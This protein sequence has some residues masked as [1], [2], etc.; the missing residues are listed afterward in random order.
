M[1]RI[2]GLFSK[3]SEPENLRQ[4]FWRAARGKADRREVQV[5]RAR[6]EDELAALGKELATNQWTPQGYRTFTVFEPKERRIHAAPFRDRVVHHAIV[7][8]CD[9]VFER[10]AIADSF[11][12]RCGK[13]QV[14]AAQRTQQFCRRH[15]FALK[16]DVRKYF[17][18]VDHAVLQAQLARVFREPTLLKIWDTVLA[19]YS[20]AS[21]RGLPI[22][23]LTSQHL[24]NFHL[25]ALDRFVKERLRR[26][27]YVR[28]M[29]DFLIWGESRVELTAV[30]REVAAFLHDELKLD[31][32]GTWAI[33]GVGAGVPFLGLRIFPARMRLLACGKRRFRKKFR[34]GHMAW[35]SGLW[36]ERLAQARMTALFGVRA[37]ADI[38]ALGRTWCREFWVA[39]TEAPT[40]SI[41]AARGTTPPAMCARPT[42]TGMSPATATTTSA[43]GSLS[44][45]A[46]TDGRRR[47]G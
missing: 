13:G 24:A 41:A 22:G 39:A 16:L 1:K 15:S 44:P 5:F 6:L 19:S 10:K 4:A 32:K 11:A 8:A 37:H 12:C 46:Q 47:Q 30:K 35:S 28:Y 27:G 7:A 38:R 2:G 33:V 31:M 9:P 29:D 20:K 34:V 17:D 42:A 25:G 14:A 18:S 23:A 45:P 26:R 36:P 40:A 21:G 43:S 3:I